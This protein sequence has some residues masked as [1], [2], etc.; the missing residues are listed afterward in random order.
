MFVYSDV[1]SSRTLQIKEGLNRILCLAPYG[2]VSFKV[3]YCYFY[4]EFFCCMTYAQSCV[5]A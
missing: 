5:S 2:I 3:F 1:L 4:L